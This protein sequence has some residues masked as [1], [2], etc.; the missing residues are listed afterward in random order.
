MGLASPQLIDSRAQAPERR[1]LWD[2]LML[3][4]AE[5]ED[6]FTRLAQGEPDERGRREMR[7][8]HPR[9]L[10]LGGGLS[11]TTAV[12]LGLLLPGEATVPRRN[13][14]SGVTMNLSGHAEVTTGDESFSVGETDVWTKPS[15]AME[16]LTNI[17]DEPFRY[18]RYSNT[19]LLETLEYYYEDGGPI[20]LFHG[21]PEP[22]EGGPRSKDLTPP[23]PLEGG[24]GEVLL[25]YEHLIDPEYVED[26]PL[27]FTWDQ[28]SQHLDRVRSL[29][30]GY[31]G[32]PLFVLYNPATGR[33]N[34]TTPSF[35]ATIAA[36]GAN[37]SGPS[38]RHMSSAIN[39]HFAGSGSSVVNGERVEWKAGDL[40]LSA[41]A[42]Q[43][44]SHTSG[45]DGALILTIQD[46][47]FHISN[48]SL[49]WQ[50]DIEHGEVIAIG[51]QAGFSTNIASAGS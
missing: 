23:I 24:R 8:V 32:R 31:T 25:P 5:I 46:H 44:H 34:G 4:A 11:P 30:S 21:G 14:A 41:P 12:S 48:G 47:P 28:V 40:M 9:A 3:R 27:H 35:F 43:E 1:E 15:M 38:H 42:W 22:V 19:A 18:L 51:N 17:S 50:E 10:G 36:F 49:V 16:T 2:P 29:K 37:F 45:P 7:V 13:N 20:G 33:L 39:Y 6:I 26:N